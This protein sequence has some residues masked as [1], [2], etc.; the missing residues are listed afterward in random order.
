MKQYFFVILLTFCYVSSSLSMNSDDDNIAKSYFSVHQESI[1]AYTTLRISS[2]KYSAAQTSLCRLA[3]LA[4]IYYAIRIGM[5]HA[6]GQ[7][8]FSSLTYKEKFVFPVLFGIYGLGTILYRY[9]DFKSACK[10][11]NDI[12]M[13]IADC[14]KRAIDNGKQL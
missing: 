4:T 3:V 14:E 10:K 9:R 2:E 13:K 5:N 11:V 1:S 7:A 6:S 12:N 8:I